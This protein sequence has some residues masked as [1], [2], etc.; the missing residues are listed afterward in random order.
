[1]Q[2]QGNKLKEIAKNSEAITKCREHFPALKRIHNGYPIA[3]L[4]GPAGTQ[5]PE[6]VLDAIVHYY[7][8]SNANTH[9]RFVTA[10]ETDQ[11]IKDTR[12]VV[13]TFLGTT[14]HHEI[15]F[16]ANMTTLTYALSIAIGRYLKKG[17]EILITQLDHEANRGP[18][19]QLQEKGIRVREISMK[20]D[21]TLDYDDCESKITEATRLV[22]MGYAS[23]ALGTVND[24]G[25]IRQLTYKVGAWLLV[26]AVHFAPHFPIDV[27]SVGVDFLLCSVYKFYGPHVGILYARRGLLDILPSD[28]LRTQ[29]QYAPYKIETGT[30]NHAAL[31]GVKAAIEYIASF[32]SGF[33]LRSRLVSA[34]KRIHDYEHELA[35][36]AYL[37]LGEIPNI[38]LY[39]PNFETENRAPTIA[40]NIKDKSATEVC[41]MLDEKAIFAWDGHFYAIR[42]IEVLGLL[43]K[44]GVIRIGISI[45]NTEEEII[46]FLKEIKRIATAVG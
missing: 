30:M 17:D 31:A 19:L 16:G 27:I 14:N 38:E 6:K 9:G 34:M 23:N 37:G 1:M 4:D 3:F 5:V 18:W 12:K 11:L 25:R 13:A 22:A 29:D 40:F 45:Y 2:N 15:S 41:S 32:G 36:V 28:H 44:G 26:D 39:G 7:I 46:R 42:P 24:I 10:T 21:G 20:L 8:T 43:E 33:D 35:E